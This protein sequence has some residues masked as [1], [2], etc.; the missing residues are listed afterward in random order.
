M[1]RVLLL[2]VYCTPVLPRPP[3]SSTG[4]VMLQRMPCC[5]GQPSRQVG[6]W[7]SSGCGVGGVTRLRVE[8]IL[9]GEQQVQ[10]LLRRLPEALP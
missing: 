10:M 4:T 9:R 7:G 3:S 8:T 6:G 1:P 5:A 2:Y